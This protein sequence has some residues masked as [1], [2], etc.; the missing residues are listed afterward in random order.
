MALTVSGCSVRKRAALTDV[1]PGPSNEGTLIER[2]IK[3]NFTNRSFF[4]SKCEIEI[5]SGVGRE[6]V[7]G[8]IKF[9]APDKYLISI[10]SKTG[11]EAARIYIDNDTILANDRINRILYCGSA[12]YLTKKY[13]FS[14]AFLP[15]LFGDFVKSEN[16]NTGEL[17]CK[18]DIVDLSVGLQGLDL[19]YTLDCNKEKLIGV[20]SEKIKNKYPIDI[21]YSDFI[22]NSDFYIPGK[23]II[24]GIIQGTKIEIYIQKIESNWNGSVEFIPGNR[25]D[26]VDL[27]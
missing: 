8:T 3:Q 16:Y 14:K 15:L 22:R 13:G 12:D 17:K 27:L 25:Y 18:G 7:I 23:V 19:N 21:K 5:I 1:R 4:I 10:R 20:K 6:S 11:I 26:I 24:D 2:A 9:Q